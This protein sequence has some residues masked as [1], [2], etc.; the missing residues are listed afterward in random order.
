MKTTT[1][2]EKWG[3]IFTITDLGKF[4]GKSPV[5]L[6]GWEKQG[7]VSIPKEPSGDRKLYIKD[8]KD[9]VEVAYER[10]RIS[11]ERR[12]LV[13]ASLTILQVVEGMNNE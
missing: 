3:F 6:R 9:I 5:T 11:K 7:L 10:K 4:L 2:P 1:D 8:V 13:L 12:E